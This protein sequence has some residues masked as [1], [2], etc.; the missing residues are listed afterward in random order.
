VVQ[1]TESTKFR[2][3][4]GDKWREAESQDLIKVTWVEDVLYAFGREEVL[5]E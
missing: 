1:S 5:S 2:S 3:L 4:K